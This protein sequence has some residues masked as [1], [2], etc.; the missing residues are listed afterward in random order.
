MLKITNKIKKYFSG[1]WGHPTRFEKIHTEI[2]EDFFDDAEGKW[3][4]KKKKQSTQKH[5]AYWNMCP[6]CMNKL[7]ELPDQSHFVL[8]NYAQSC[9][10]GAKVD[11]DCPACHRST[12]VKDKVYKHQWCGCGF[13][14]QRKEGDDK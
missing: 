6:F 3:Y 7:V 11:A 14:G 9:E 12:W 1:N 4:S 13:V 2:P 8:R 5:T 10:C